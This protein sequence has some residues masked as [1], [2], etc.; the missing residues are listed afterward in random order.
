L[1]KIHRIVW[2][3][4]RQAFIVAHENAATKGKPSSTQKAV[5]LAVSSALLA[6]SA[7]Q[8]L[9]YDYDIG[10]ADPDSVF[11]LYLYNGDT[12]NVQAGHYI[13]PFSAHQRAVGISSSGDTVGGI[14]NSGTIAGNP[15][16][17][18]IDLY[19]N[20]TLT[21]LIN[22]ATGTISGNIGV[23]LATVASIGTLTNEGLILGSVQ[24][25]IALQNASAGSI[26]NSGRIEGNDIAIELSGSTITGD[27]FN[28]TSGVIEGAG[29]GVLLS[30]SSTI[31]GSLI[32]QGA[33]TGSGVLSNSAGVHVDS[34]TISGGIT[35]SGTLSSI[36]G[37][38]GIYLSGATSAW[39][40]SGPA[41]VMAKV[42][43]AIQNSGRIEGTTGDG[44]RL[45]GAEVGSIV[46]EGADATITGTQA[47]IRIDSRDWAYYTVGSSTTASGVF[48]SSVTAG[49]TN[50]GS[51]LG[52]TNGIF[53]GQS[54]SVGGEILNSGTISG[55]NTAIL[56]TGGAV[57]T[58][59]N[60]SSAGEISGGTNGI[61]LSG[62]TISGGLTNSGNISG[63]TNYGIGVG[64]TSLIAGGITNSGSIE[65][66]NAGVAVNSSTVTGGLTNS[67]LIHSAN[68]NGIDLRSSLL[69]GGITNSASGTISSGTSGPV[70][71]Y[72]NSTSLSGG[73]NNHGLIS[74]DSAA[75]RIYYSE[76]SD[77]I[78]NGATGTIEALSNFGVAI[79]VT[80][81]FSTISG[82]INNQGLISGGRAGISVDSQSL[83]SGGITNSGA[84]ATISGDVAI[85]VASSSTIS[86]GITNSGSI[87]GS[88]AGIR[89]LSSSLIA[90]GITNSGTISG[91][92][93]AICVYGGSLDSIHVQGNSTANFSGGIYAPLTEMFIDSGSTYTKDDGDDFTVMHLTNNGTFNLGVNNT[94]EL[95]GNFINNGI[96]RPTITDSG[97]GKLIVDG[98]VTLGGTL[99]VDVKAGGLTELLSAGNP[100][101]GTVNDII[102]ATGTITSTFATLD[103]NST[104]FDFTA[105]YNAQDVDLTLVAASTG[106]GGGSNGV[107]NSV[108]NTGNTP[109]TGAAT[110]FDDLIDDY[111]A[112]GSTGN[113]E[114][115]AILATLGGMSTEEEVSNAV[116]QVLPLLTGSATVAMTSAMHGLNRIVQA[117]QEGQHGRSTGDE[118]YGDKH[119]WMKPFGSW[120]DQDNRN[121]VSGYEADTYGLVF[122]ADAEFGEVNRVGLGFSY[123]NSDVDGNSNVA[124]NSADVDSYQLVIY[125]SRSLTGKTELSYQADV[126]YHK[127]QGRRSVSLL[128]PGMTAKSDYDSWSGHL[129]LALAHSFDLSDKTS[130]T[131]SVRMDYTR[132]DSESY[133]EK[134]APGLNLDVSDTTAEELILSVDGKLAH[135][136]TDR[137][138]VTANLGIGYDVINEASSITSSFAGTPSTAFTT[139]GLDPD[140]WSYRGGL[141]IVG[142]VTETVEVTARYDFE[143][144][145]DF[146]NQTASLKVRWAF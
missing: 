31:A 131:P 40:T 33:I 75:I 42:S 53:V 124:P 132:V 54:S 140:A 59:I 92:G 106:S 58:S 18:G 41:P 130:L 5:A 107:L 7:G 77:G 78:S 69:T 36:S 35:N 99:F 111:L 101:A 128:L 50:S 143:L 9:A 82:G 4:A 108:N 68:G 16:G 6:L 137:A 10:G 49:I 28:D 88:S 24:R 60:N 1:N 98:D 65:G 115:D 79:D 23:F 51:I 135:Q 95:V 123:A 94:G 14:T 134:G 71:I 93:C 141:G 144:K 43:G 76:I 116:S 104:L 96:L 22:H 129:G 136:L 67:G 12:L 34:S 139:R 38:H 25:G 103:D 8:A 122:G 127:T 109:A 19:S 63:S 32:N 27:I 126:G 81:S 80:E 113:P 73:I 110:V 118:F 26:T 46:N 105:V 142:N 72:L 91:S 20:T 121:G 47:G 48:N 120:A 21:T 29:S 62:G 145:E 37:A 89:V 39:T 119:F 57:V 83:I 90:G 17:N 97:Y 102:T 138:T 56:V 30:I 45:S 117:R 15:T 112:N 11:S 133:T 146:D 55:G 3:I 86:G 74:G 52:N 70:A 2:S 125:G 84:S 61:V 66:G 64:S 44:I 87:V 114:M 13:A 100:Y 85:S